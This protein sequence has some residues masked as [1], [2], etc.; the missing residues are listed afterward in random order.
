MRG[1]EITIRTKPMR[2]SQARTHRE[3]FGCAKAASLSM[4][5]I[6][7]F[8]LRIFLLFPNRENIL[9]KTASSPFKG[10][11]FKAPL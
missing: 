10:R 8:D 7:L 6:L 11:R 3:F 9:D 4:L 5:Q 1:G 2:P